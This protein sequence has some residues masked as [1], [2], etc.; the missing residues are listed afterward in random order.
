MARDIVCNNEVDM[1][2]ERYRS[3]FEGREFWFD[4]K[5]CKNLFDEHPEKYLRNE[6]SGFIPEVESARPAEAPGETLESPGARDFRDIGEKTLHESKSRA[7]SMF[8]ERKDYVA[9][10]A[11][12]ISRALHEAS[13]NLRDE[14]HDDSARFVDRAADEVERL[15]RRFRDEDADRLI[16]D[17]ED[18]VR[19]NPGLSI[20]GALAAGF[21][22]ARFVKSGSSESRRH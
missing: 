16:S 11:G 10:N 12:S 15:S 6:V 2:K 5:Q 1:E 21:L 3:I 18:Y 20:G 8:S 19:G 4:T 22:L 17:A 9:D 7:K 13:K 14:H